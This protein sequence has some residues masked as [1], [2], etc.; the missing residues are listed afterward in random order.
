MGGGPVLV[1]EDEWWLAV[2]FWFRFGY[3]HYELV[4]ARSYS[5]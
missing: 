1:E 2:G 5:Q 4:R 3:E